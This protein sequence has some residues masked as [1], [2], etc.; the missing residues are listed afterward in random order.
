MVTVTPREEEAVAHLLVT[1]S[2]STIA[3]QEQDAVKRSRREV[4]E[5]ATGAQTKTMPK[6]PRVLSPRE[7]RVPL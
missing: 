5:L 4:V 1:E 3:V 6:K 7:R 2:V